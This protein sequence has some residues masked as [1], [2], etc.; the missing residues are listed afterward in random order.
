MRQRRFLICFERM[1]ESDSSEVG[2]SRLRWVEILRELEI[3]KRAKREKMQERAR[4]KI[5]T[6]LRQYFPSAIPERWRAHARALLGC[7][8]ESKTD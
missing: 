5:P 1:N 7:V 8:G 4:R 2:R 3:T 6:D